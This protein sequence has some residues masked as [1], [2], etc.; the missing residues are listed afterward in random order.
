MI[1][2][3]RF[4]TKDNTVREDQPNTPERQVQQV[5]QTP[6]KQQ[7]RE[8]SHLQINTPDSQINKTV[9]P[10]SSDSNFRSRTTEN[11]LPVQSQSAVPS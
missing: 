1:V 10:N 9:W 4:N 7:S 3:T 8:T 5:E 11:Q 2:Q 6:E